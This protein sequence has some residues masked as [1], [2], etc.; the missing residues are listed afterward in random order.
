[1]TSR[2]GWRRPATVSARYISLTTV[3]AYDLGEFL[4]RRSQVRVLLG[5]PR[6]LGFWGMGNRERAVWVLF[7]SRRCV[8]AYAWTLVDPRSGTT[9]AGIAVIEPKSTEKV[10]RWDL[11]LHLA[12]DADSL[13]EPLADIMTSS[14]SADCACCRVA[15][16]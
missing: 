13:S 10:S 3:T 6:S 2:D 1:M 15:E 7:A 8:T 16:L 9:S 12:V 5:S 4:N 11:H 14:D